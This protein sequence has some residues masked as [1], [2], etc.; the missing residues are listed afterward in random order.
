MTTIKLTDLAGIT[1]R[2]RDAIRNMQARGLLPW[3]DERQQGAYRRFDGTHAL[4]LIVAEV[5]Q[6]QNI[7]A[8]EVAEFVICQRHAVGAF[9]DA[10][11]AGAELPDLFV[12]AILRAVED[13]NTVQWMPV[14]GIHYGTDEELRDFF[15]SELAM[16][17]KTSA[18]KRIIGGPLV[19][20]ASLR[21][22]YRI[23]RIRADA[24][25]FAIM[26]RRIVPASDVNGARK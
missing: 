1:G 3:Q 12:S 10:A 18:G 23:L 25:G 22:A 16:V 24:A 19:A 6:S 26:G 20:V 4:A 21:E 7:P 9:L 11:D 17:G 14:H 13:P 8:V 2:S 15:A 5:L